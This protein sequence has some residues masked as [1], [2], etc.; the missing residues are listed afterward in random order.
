MTH[1]IK[2][3]ILPVA[4]LGTR[5]LPATKAVPKE[6]MPV[7]DRP[8]IQLAVD[9]AVAAGIERLVFV[10]HPSKSM[11][12]DYLQHDEDLIEELESRGKTELAERV[13]D[14]V[15]D[16]PVECIFV[17]QDE[18]LGLGHAILCARDCA[19]DGPVAVILPDDVLLGAGSTIGDMADAYD[20]KQAAHMVATMRVPKSDVSK[21]GIVDNGDA[22][23]GRQMPVRGLVEKP[24][25]DDAPSQMA[26]IGRYILAASIFDA[27]AETQPGAGGEIQ[28]TDAIAA[29]IGE[30]G[31]TSF[32]VEQERFDCGNPEGLLEASLALREIVEEQGRAA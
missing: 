3:A 20:P 7:Y 32:E 17:M 28:L 8:L 16:K 9:E 5:L 13:Q 11:I 21:Y 14:A 10:S 24:D 6:L 22:P 31:V 25:P 4:G 26:V 1:P 30:A 18:P 12:E 2:T 15:P 19:G 27:L 29:A 23:A